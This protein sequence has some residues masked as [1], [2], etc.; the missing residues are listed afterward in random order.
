M[1]VMQDLTAALR[2]VAKMQDGIKLASGTVC[3]RQNDVDQNQ[4]VKLPF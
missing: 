3:Q 4:N 2:K 1:A